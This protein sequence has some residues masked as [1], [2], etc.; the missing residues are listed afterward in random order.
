MVAKNFFNGFKNFKTLQKLIKDLH[1]RNITI[2]ETEMK[3]DEFKSLINQAKKFDK[4][5]AYPARGSKYIDL[6][7][8]VSK[9]PKNFMTDGR[10]LFMC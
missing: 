7:E 5:K 2:D 3:Q 8:I 6:K 10:K 1:N 9:N 4:L